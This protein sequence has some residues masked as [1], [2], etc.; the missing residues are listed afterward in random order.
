MLVLTSL[1]SRWTPLFNNGNFCG[2]IFGS[3]RKIL[4]ANNSEQCRKA[5]RL[6]SQC[7]DTI[8][9][10]SKRGTFICRCVMNGNSCKVMTADQGADEDLWC[11]VEKFK[12]LSKLGKFKFKNIRIVSVEILASN[13]KV[14]FLVFKDVSR[15]R[16][17]QVE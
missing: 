1:G 13:F 3:V 7:S 6:D 5:A 8:Y 10:C 17:L 4:I 14:R 16:F 11:T 9:Y 15:C 12:T 2:G